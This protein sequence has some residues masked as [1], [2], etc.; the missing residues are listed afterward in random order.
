MKFTWWTYF[1]AIR[2]AL[3]LEADLHSQH[4]A[5]FRGP[6]AWYKQTKFTNLLYARAARN[7]R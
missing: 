3:K 7:G 6:E 5:C 4:M 1:V 2:R